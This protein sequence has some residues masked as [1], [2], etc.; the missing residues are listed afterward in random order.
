MHSKLEYIGFYINSRAE[1]LSTKRRQKIRYNLQFLLLLSHVIGNALTLM[2]DKVSA[3]RV[4]F[5]YFGID[6]V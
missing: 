2:A 6:F 3:R 1:E 4:W 5:K